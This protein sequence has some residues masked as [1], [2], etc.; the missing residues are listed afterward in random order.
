MI[1][2]PGETLAVA[3]F[4]A[5]GGMGRAGIGMCG[6]YPGINDVVLF[7][8]DTNMR[9][10]I[11]EGKPYPRDFVEIRQWLKEGKLKA[12][13]VEIYQ[14]P[15]PNILCQDGDLFAT[16]TAAMGGWGDVLERDLCLG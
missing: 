7:A 10:L 2:G 1:V 3:T 15:T 12:G 6:G 16:A 5:T 8:H 14:S 11:K 4:A 9:E 13:S